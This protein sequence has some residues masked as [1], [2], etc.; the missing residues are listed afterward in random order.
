MT[1]LL[2]A[3]PTGLLSPVY[4]L[5]EGDAAIGSL[6]YRPLSLRQ[7]GTITTAGQQFSVSR[8][9]VLSANYLLVGQDGLVRATANR[10]GIT[11]T[12]FQVACGG[13]DVLLRKK[14][15]A[16]RESYLLSDAGGEVGLVARESLV[17]RQM[18]IRLD[19]RAAG[20]P[21]ELILLLAWI[22]GMI[23]RSNDGSPA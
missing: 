16:L 17:S 10:H 13:F 23:H 2:K 19:E 20:M 18:A 12:A 22:A 3:V 5:R 14:I 9:G 15:L 8:E 11:G 21:A 1:R 7:K 6:E 4:E